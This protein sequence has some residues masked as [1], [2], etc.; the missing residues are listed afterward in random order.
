MKRSR[1]ERKTVTPPLFL[2][3][4]LLSTQLLS[5]EGW[6]WEFIPLTGGDDAG[7]PTPQA[8]HELRPG[9]AAA[10]T[11]EGHQR[12]FLL[13]TLQENES[14]FTFLGKKCVVS[15]R[16]PPRRPD[17]S[18]PGPGGSAGRWEWGRRRERRRENRT[19]GQAFL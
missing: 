2:V 10:A 15:G 9:A 7:L 13:L 1:F 14:L 4:V 12:G 8:K 6:S 11:A 19:A 16:D 17:L 18:L 3:I 5:K